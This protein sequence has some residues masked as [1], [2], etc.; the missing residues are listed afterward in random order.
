M[1]DL[2]IPLDILSP[3]KKDGTLIKINLEINQNKI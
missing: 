3:K 1:C 2:F